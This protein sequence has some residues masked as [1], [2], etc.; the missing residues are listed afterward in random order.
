MKFQLGPEGWERANG[1]LNELEE[2]S[3]KRKK[4][5]Q[6]ESSICS[7]EEKKLPNFAQLRTNILSLPTWVA[8]PGWVNSQKA[9]EQQGTGRGWPF[10]H[11]LTYQRSFSGGS[12]ATFHGPSDQA[13]PDVVNMKK[14]KM[15]QDLWKNIF[16]L[17]FLADSMQVCCPSQTNSQTV[18]PS[19]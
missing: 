16:E 8:G 3:R 13:D 4:Q 2:L 1:R 9:P 19:R 7:R 5:T 12:R 11:S 15:T 6:W 18:F 14:W 10:L 17:P